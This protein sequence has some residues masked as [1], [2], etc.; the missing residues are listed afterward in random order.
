[1][2]AQLEMDL[3]LKTHPNYGHYIITC[4]NHNMFCCLIAFYIKNAYLNL[5]YKHYFMETQCMHMCIC[6]HT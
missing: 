4:K 5:K 6:A 2:Y 3:L 1:M